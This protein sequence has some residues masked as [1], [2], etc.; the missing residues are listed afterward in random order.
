MVGGPRVTFSKSSFSLAGFVS[1]NLIISFPLNVT[2]ELKEKHSQLALRLT[3][4][5]IK[6][7]YI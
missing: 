6:D 1:S 4:I 7:R 5:T 3:A 2:F